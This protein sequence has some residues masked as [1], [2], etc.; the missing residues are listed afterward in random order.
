MKAAW[1]TTEKGIAYLAN[2]KRTQRANN[3][4]TTKAAY[5]RRMAWLRSGD[6]TP[7]ELRAIYQE[8]LGR[9]HYCGCLV[10]RPRFASTELRGFDHVIPRI[11]GGKHTASNMVVCCKLCNARKA[12][13][14]VRG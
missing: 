2:H 4:E 13:E 10:E 1:C 3:P 5:E 12:K 8:S 11:Q 9:C 6:V 14:D 7:E